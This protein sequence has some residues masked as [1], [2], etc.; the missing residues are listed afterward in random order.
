MKPFLVSLPPFRPFRTHRVAE[1]VFLSL[2]AT[3]GYYSGDMK[4]I[5]AD[6]GDFKPTVFAGVPRVLER[7]YTG[8]LDKV[9]FK[10]L[11]H[12]LGFGN[13]GLGIRRRGGGAR[14]P[15]RAERDG[16]DV[17]PFCDMP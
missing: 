8:V 6:C 14:V 17:V 15:V 10:G 9:G 12:G 7:V 2:G 5:M 13:Q 16:I 4:R 3:I 11:K 1:E